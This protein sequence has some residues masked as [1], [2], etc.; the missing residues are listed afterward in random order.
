[1]LGTLKT[2]FAGPHHVV[3]FAEYAAR[4]LADVLFRKCHRYRLSL[5]FLATLRPTLLATPPNGDHREG[6]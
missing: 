5:V 3:D 6:T 4:H 1:M 2:A